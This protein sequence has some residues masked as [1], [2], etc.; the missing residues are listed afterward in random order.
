MSSGTISPQQAKAEADIDDLIAD[1]YHSPLDFVRIMWPWG[2]AGT[3]LE[4]EPGP[5][6]W[7]IECLEDIGRRCLEN[8]FDG[9]HAVPALRKAISKGHGVGGSVMIAWLTTWIMATRPHAQGTVTANT[10]TQ[11]ETKTWPTITRWL[12]LSL[13]G[14]RF[15][16]NT[17]RM[18]HTQH[19]ESWFCSAQTCREEN[20]EAF[21]GQHAKD[22]SSFYMFDEDSAVPDV[23]HT[24]AE[25]GLTDGEPFIVLSGNATRTTGQFYRACFG[26]ERQRWHPT[27]V[28]SRTSRF[29]NKATIQEWLELYGEDSDFFR[30]RVRGLPPKA[31][32]AQFIDQ[33]RVLEA[34]KR[35][36]VVFGDEPLLAGADLA[37]GGGDDNVIRFRCGTDARS[38]PPIRVKGEFTRDP[39]I[40]T[41]RLGDV[42]SRPHNGR[43]V[44]MLFLDSAGIAGPIGHRLRQMGYR[45]VVDVNF[46]SDSPDTQCRYMRDY[47]WQKMK[48]WLLAGAIDSDPQ[49]EADLLGPGI[50]PDNQQRV[51]L[52]DKKTMKQRGLDSPDDADALALTF[53]MPVKAVRPSAGRPLPRPQQDGWAV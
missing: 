13:V 41:T 19:R 34:Q 39:A 4:H 14:H 18:Y 20:S 44:T 6:T 26:S 31:S 3:P 27:I 49:L 8:A 37:W 51:W 1:C 46:G 9:Q 53:A 48:E 32:D 43:M 5:D 36:V 40:L 38:I 28:D 25:G 11:L 16:I 15:T 42:L 22:S 24:V 52:E 12:K 23:I 10:S 17:A 33:Q 35:Q 50:R 2:E 45:N 47:M 29:T 7:Q 30:V 21:A